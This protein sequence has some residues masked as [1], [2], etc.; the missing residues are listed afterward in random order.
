[1][2]GGGGG[3]TRTVQPEGTSVH[4]PV[5]DL[6]ANSSIAALGNFLPFTG[7]GA[8]YHYMPSML[9][10]QTYM[11][12]P[13]QTI[14]GNPFNNAQ[15]QVPYTGQPGMQQ[16]SY[17]QALPSA[18][19]L[20]GQQQSANNVLAQLLL[21]HFAG[22]M[23]Q[24]QPAAQQQPSQNQSGGGESSPPQQQQQPQQNSGPGQQISLQQVL[25]ALGLQTPFGG[26]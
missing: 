20:Q 4:T 18:N 16:T 14:Y 6:L 7:Y 25:A 22:Q 23:P 12:G 15:T 13:N 19:T 11:A 3:E 5:D 17:Q 10:G 8:G 26:A 2:G 21:G 9:L 1:M 24:Q